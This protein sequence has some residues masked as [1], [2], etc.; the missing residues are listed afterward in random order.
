MQCWSLAWRI[1]SITLL[2]WEMSAIVQWFE[3]SLILPFL[4]IGMR[5]YLFQFCDYC[6]VFQICWH[7]ECSTS[8][9]PSFRILNSSAGIP[10]PPLTL[11]IAVCPKAHLTLH[12]R[13]FGSGWVTRPLWLSRSLRFFWYSFSVYSFHRFFISSSSIRTLPFLSFIVPI[14]GWNIPSI[15]SI[16]LKDLFLKDL[17]WFSSISLRYSLKKAFLSLLV[18]LWNSA[19]SWVYFPFSPCFSFLFFLRLFVKT[20]QT[21]ALPS[22]F[23]FS[24]G[25]FC[26][27]PPVQH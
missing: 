11:L 20:P 12:S 19:F 10:S 21:T 17:H 4:G 13:K 5:I 7:I 14:F 3:Y 25:W 9:A 16:F 6:Q 27:L 23:S 18:I 26:S 24:L 8:I 1:L 15:F 22:C 2:A